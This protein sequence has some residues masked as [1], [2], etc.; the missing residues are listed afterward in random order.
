MKDN[1]L[2]KKNVPL[3]V[4]VLIWV[5][6][7]VFVMA[8]AAW[9]FQKPI[10][11]AIAV[12]TIQERFAIQSQKLDDGL[13]AGLAGTGAPFPDVNRVGPCIVVAAGKHLYIV[14]CGD[15]AAR[16]ISLMGFQIGKVDAI[17]LTHFHSDHIAGLGEMM[18]QRWANGSN[19]SPVDVIGPE[20][21]DEV[22]KGYNDAYKLDAEYRVAHHG[23]ATVPQS[24]A[25]GTARPFNLSAGDDASTVV[26]DED[27]VRI[28][29][30]KVNHAPVYPAV[31]YRFDYGG[32]SLVISGDTEPCDS[33]KKQS[34]GVDVLLHEA[35]QDSLMKLINE[36]AAIA[37][38]ASTAR[39]TADIPSYHAT[40]EDA[41]RI[42]GEA[43]VR[44]L[45][46]YHILPPLPQLLTGMFLGDSSKYY[47]GPITVGEDGMLISLPANSDKI[48]LKNL[49][50]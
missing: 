24:G 20:G 12:K 36:Q 23:A 44:H 30:F 35:L 28:T 17:L 6:A 9:I 8:G 18:L 33:L 14:D 49:L 41:A 25:G 34:M 38:S 27:G 50:K 7:A 16:N 11:T 39:I 37:P 13:Y 15:G 45:V 42:A 22:V 5:L 19:A 29:A 48:Y 4:K 26:A 1:S 32:R 21:V 47:P 3:A 43:G 2:P 46:L 10:F 40:P 31:G